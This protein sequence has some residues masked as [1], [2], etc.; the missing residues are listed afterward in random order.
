MKCVKDVDSRGRS[1][2]GSR[3]LGSTYIGQAGGRAVNQVLILATAEMSPGKRPGTV[4]P[5]KAKVLEPV[6]AVCGLDYGKEKVRAAESKS[7]NQDHLN[8]G[9]L[10]GKLHV[11][12][13]QLTRASPS[14]ARVLFAQQFPHLE[15]DLKKAV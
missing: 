10:V 3:L 7:T 14:Q 11:L 5:Q 6:E 13:D 4:T 9:S 12:A 15:L 1:I 2:V 8:L